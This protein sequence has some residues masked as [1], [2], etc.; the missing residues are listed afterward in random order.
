MCISQDLV[1]LDKFFVDPRGPETNVI[2]TIL[3]HDS[4]VYVA[5]SNFVVRINTKVCLQ[6]YL[7]TSY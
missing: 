2:K 7:I 1:F 6:L 3:Q 4:M 5:V